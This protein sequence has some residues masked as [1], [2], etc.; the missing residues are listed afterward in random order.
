MI[1]YS[2]FHKYKSPKYKK[3]YNILAQYQTGKI[4]IV[5]D[6]ARTHHAKLIQPFLEKN[7]SRLT[8]VL[9]PPYSP[10]LNL[11]EA[12]WGWLKFNVVNNLFF[13]KVDEIRTDINSFLDTINKVPW[14]I[15]DRLCSRL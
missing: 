5:L 6:N 14:Q 1:Q 12:L 15:I 7:K 10:N 8:L 3:L 2:N 11:I 4:V 9:L 13:S